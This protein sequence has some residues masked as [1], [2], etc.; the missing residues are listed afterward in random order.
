[1]RKALARFWTLCA[2]FDET[3][4]VKDTT[5]VLFKLAGVGAQHELVQQ[6]NEELRSFLQGYEADWKQP[7]VGFDA[8]G[9]RTFLDGFAATDRRSLQR[10]VETRVLKG[11]KLQDVVESAKGVQVRPHCVEALRLADEWRVISANW[12]DALVQQV[13]ESR[14]LSESGN[15]IANEL[16]IADGASTGEIHVQVQSPMD[17]AQCIAKLRASQSTNATI[18]Y[19]GDSANDLLALLEADVGVWLTPTHPSAP[20]LLHRLVQRYGI[21]VQPLCNYSTIG[22]CLHAASQRQRGDRPLLFTTTDWEQLAGALKQLPSRAES[23]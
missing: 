3:I 19:V 14:G 13:L 16:A 12:S 10:V 8:A 11:I 22:D 21:D 1:M 23:T 7:A 6:Y 18:V 20:S 2:D 4:T 17:K 9:L 15:V 5:A